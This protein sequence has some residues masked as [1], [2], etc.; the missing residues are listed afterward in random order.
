MS[1]KLKILASIIVAG[2][3]FF[4]V[5]LFSVPKVQALCTDEDR[6]AMRCVHTVHS[7]TNDDGVAN[8]QS[9]PSSNTVSIYFEADIMNGLRACDWNLNI[10][11]ALYSSGGTS[12]SGAGRIGTFIVSRSIVGG[13]EHTFCLIHPD[14][15]EYQNCGYI[16]FTTTPPAQPG[17]IQVNSNIVTNWSFAGS[18]DPCT[19]GPCNG[20]SSVRYQID[21][22]ANPSYQIFP[23][24]ISGYNVST[25]STVG[26][27]ESTFHKYFS[28]IINTVKAASCNGSNSCSVGAGQLVTFNITYTEI[29]PP[30]GATNCV[31]NYF[32]VNGGS[33]A[34]INEGESVTL[35]WSVNT[36]TSMTVDGIDVPGTGSMQRG[37]LSASRSFALYGNGLNGGSCSATVPVTVNDVPPPPERPGLPCLIDYFPSDNE[38]NGIALI[39]WQTS[40]A[41][42]VVLSGGQFG[43]GISVSPDG[44]TTV[45]IDQNTMYTLTASGGCSPTATADAWMYAE[46][47][48]PPPPQNPCEIRSYIYFNNSF[49]A[50]P[51]HLTFRLVGPATYYDEDDNW[52]NSITGVVPGTYTI[53]YQSPANLYGYLS[54]QQAADPTTVYCAPGGIARFYLKYFSRPVLQIR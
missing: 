33:Q 39:Q 27:E 44:S 40:N 47:T 5:Q 9:I 46:G 23:G 7:V 42:N 35:T 16:W 25:S 32:R 43:S 14:Y 29:P 53:Y 49:P 10:D 34:T 54:D 31:V 18:P 11:S 37:P 21:A 26:L 50:T 20:V 38:Y 30:P 12:C 2:G 8:S 45:S 41:N 36:V 28:K 4:T 52:E 13:G 15:N 22:T 51:T 17:Q 1:T 24:S 3:T 6:V 19:S 48:P